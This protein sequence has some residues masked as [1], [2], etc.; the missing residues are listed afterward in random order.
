VLYLLFH[1]PRNLFADANALSKKKIV[2]EK[3]PFRFRETKDL[4]R[5][6]RN[7]FSLEIIGE[8]LNSAQGRTMD[9]LVH[10]E[11]PSRGRLTKQ[12]IG[13]VSRRT[14]RDCDWDLWTMN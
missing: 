10:G 5:P 4:T 2:K 12:S 7:I 13:N 9:L 14:T 6:T 1:F 8:N 3:A 11:K